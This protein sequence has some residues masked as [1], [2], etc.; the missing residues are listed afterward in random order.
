MGRELIT[1]QVETF[2]QVIGEKINLLGKEFILSLLEKSIKDSLSME[3]FKEKEFS[4][5]QMENSMKEILRMGF[6]MAKEYFTG[7]MD[8]GLKESIRMES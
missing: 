3:Y 1:I 7:M 2:T 4:P 5:I 6:L 8:V